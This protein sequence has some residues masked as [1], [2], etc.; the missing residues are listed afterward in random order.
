VIGGV[1]VGPS[2]G[3]ALGFV[4]ESSVGGPSLLASFL[5]TKVAGGPFADLSRPVSIE[6]IWDF[7]RFAGPGVHPSPRVV[8]EAIDFEDPETKVRWSTRRPAET[9]GSERDWDLRLVRSGDE[10][11]L[12]LYLRPVS[13]VAELTIPVRTLPVEFARWLELLQPREGVFSQVSLSVI[14][15]SAAEELTS[16]P[17]A[18]Q[19]TG[20]EL[21]GPEETTAAPLPSAH[22]TR[23]GA[24]RAFGRLIPLPISVL[25]LLV[26][27][28]ATGGWLCSR[29]YR[30]KPSAVAPTHT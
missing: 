23:S 22:P 25:A 15:L 27:L 20:V 10:V 4:L 7:R 24:P 2:V 21:F 29:I 18:E 8:L 28:L 19:T 17:R 13:A 5:V 9:V 6:L 12:E 3:S 16:R 1:E 30:T 11:F 26:S 14:A